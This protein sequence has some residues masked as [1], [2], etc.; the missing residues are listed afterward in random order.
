MGKNK[1]LNEVEKGQVQILKGNGLSNRELGRQI[2]ISEKVVRNYL[3]LGDTYGAAPSKC[4]RNTT[5]TRR[6]TNIIKEEATKNKLT[7]LKIVAQLQLPIGK[8]RV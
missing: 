3:K 2:K 7:S 5:V 4:K 6:Q 8:H 1:F